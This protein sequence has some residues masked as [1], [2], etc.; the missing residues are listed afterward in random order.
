VFLILRQGSL[1]LGPAGR[2]LNW[3]RCCGAGPLTVSPGPWLT[4]EFIG[5]YRSC[6]SHGA[7]GRKTNMKAL[8]QVPEKDAPPEIAA[9]YADIQRVSGV[10]VVNLIWRHFAALPGVL[11]WAWNA[12]SPLV[13]SAAMDAARERIAS[14]AALP[15]V[16]PRDGGAWREA[17]VGEKQWRRLMAMDDVYI[18][19]NLT[20]VV[21]LT[22][23]RLRLEHPDRPAARF[24]TD[25][26]KSPALQKPDPLPCI[27]DVEPDLAAKVRML[28]RRHEGAGDG[29][30]PSLYLALVQWPGV[31]AN[32]PDW[33]SSLYDPPAL[34]AARESI[35]SHAEAEAQ[36][37]L[38]AP[39]PAPDGVGAMQ[40]A[41]QL[42]TRVI[43]PDLIA[44]CIT[45][46]RLAP[47]P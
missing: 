38:P 37:L 36:A 3:T 4:R 23:L 21:A 27:E 19:G 20:N 28:A 40:P 24:P 17:G 22:A 44:V 10:P 47:L 2:G 45:L 35:C 18:R 39:G 14:S 46:R 33:L 29:L 7:G 42:F 41:L 34:R 31:I 25:K 11:P 12:V 26:A 8:P 9:V 15:P 32:L 16:P 5:L 30:I 6:C 13:G 43:I 1:T